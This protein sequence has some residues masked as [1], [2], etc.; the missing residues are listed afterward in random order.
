MKTKF[1]QTKYSIEIIITAIRI[2]L[3]YS[4]SY[5]N[6]EEVLKEQGIIVEY[7]RIFRW[8]NKYI[9]NLLFK[10]RKYNLKVGEE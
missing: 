7:I 1:S 8:V 9:Q 2:Y 3:S 5:P 10:F 6:V 4:V